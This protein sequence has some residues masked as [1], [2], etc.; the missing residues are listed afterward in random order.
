VNS[1]VPAVLAA[2]ALALALWPSRAAVARSRLEAVRPLRGAPAGSRPGRPPSD[3]PARPRR[4]RWALA[5]AAGVGGGL[6]L[7]GAAGLL[8]GV[9]LAVAAERL[10]RRVAEDGDPD[11]RAVLDDLPFACDLL[12][13]C[14]AAGLPPG[15]ALV[16]VAPAVDGPLGATLAHVAGRYRLGA[17]PRRAWAGVPEE[18]AAVARVLVRAAES[19]SGVQPALRALAAEAR[20]SVRTATEASVRRAGVWVLAPLALCFLPAFVCLGVAPLVIGIARDV[21]G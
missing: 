2:L 14:L 15:G 6:L 9:A 20:A 13:V 4:R 19:G 16:A 3:S 8:V 12:A 10:L 21:F 18:L 7:G 5:V 1:Q 17:D 11:R